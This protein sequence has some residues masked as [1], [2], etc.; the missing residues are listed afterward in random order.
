MRGPGLFRLDV[1]LWVSWNSGL[2]V[3]SVTGFFLLQ[4]RKPPLASLRFKLTTNLFPFL[5]STSQVCTL[6]ERL[7]PSL[8][9]RRKVSLKWMSD[10]CIGLPFLR[11]CDPR[12]AA[13]SFASPRVDA[14]YA[15]RRSRRCFGP[16]GRHSRASWPIG[17]RGVRPFFP[18]SLVLSRGGLG[19]RVGLPT[20]R[21]FRDQLTT[22]SP[23]A[24]CA[25]S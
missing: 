9:G 13:A 25:G 22:A 19:A 24:R 6:R 7:A 11:F 23:Q 2:E 18:L 3:D 20:M 17:P 5:L 10:D 14:P 8:F 12:K 21:R 15:G 1:R 16:L 4:Y